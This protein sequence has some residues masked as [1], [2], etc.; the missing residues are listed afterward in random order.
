MTDVA[1]EGEWNWTSGEPITYTNWARGEPMDTFSIE[2]DYGLMES[3][4]KW[5]DVGLKVQNGGC[6][7]WP[8]SKRTVGPPKRR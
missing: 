7:K 4:G 1:K 2:E 3:A 8:S 6:P 5:F